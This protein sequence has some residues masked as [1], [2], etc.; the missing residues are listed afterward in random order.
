MNPTFRRWLPF[1]FAVAI[2]AIVTLYYVF[3]GRG[4]LDINMRQLQNQNN[5][6]KTTTTEKNTIIVK[7]KNGESY[8]IVYQEGQTKYDDLVY[9]KC[10]SAGVEK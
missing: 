5:I 10:G 2:A 8:E 1:C 3:S 7:C 9:N 6:E 4:G